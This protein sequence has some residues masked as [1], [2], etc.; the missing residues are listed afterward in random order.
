MKSIPEQFKDNAEFLRLLKEYDVLDKGLKHTKE[1]TIK[2]TVTAR[3]E[4]YNYSFLDLHEEYS[5]NYKSGDIDNFME[6]KEVKQFQEETDLR[7]EKLCHD[8]DLFAKSIN[9]DPDIF[10]TKYIYNSNKD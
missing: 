8:C 7:I 4:E 6:S 2:I 1:I 9:M 10:F 5:K 3:W